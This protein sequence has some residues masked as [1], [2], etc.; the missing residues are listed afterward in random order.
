MLA[1]PWIDVII[2]SISGVFLLYLQ[3]TAYID[4]L[5]VSVVCVYRFINI[6]SSLHNTEANR[7]TSIYTYLSIH[8]WMFICV[9]DCIYIYAIYLCVYIYTIIVMVSANLTFKTETALSFPFECLA[10]WSCRCETG[11]FKTE[12][13]WRKWKWLQKDFGDDIA[14]TSHAHHFAVIKFSQHLRSAGSSAARAHRQNVWFACRAEICSAECLRCWDIW[15]W[16]TRNKTYYRGFLLNKMAFKYCHLWVGREDIL[17]VWKIPSTTGTMIW[18][19]LCCVLTQ[20][21]CISGK[22]QHLK[23]K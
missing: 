13:R 23:G 15:M 1:W 4:S 20:L 3:Y 16:D 10:A 14:C 17:S 21:I 18:K 6:Y 7:H 11:G 5:S 9:C 12:W 2:L 8:L 22:L 19:R